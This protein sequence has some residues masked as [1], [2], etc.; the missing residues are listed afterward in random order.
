MNWRRVVNSKH[1]WTAREGNV[2]YYLYKWTTGWAWEAH[3]PLF[4]AQSAQDGT[5]RNMKSQAEAFAAMV[6]GHNIEDEL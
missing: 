2:N 6:R 3:A 4:H 1:H 5:Y